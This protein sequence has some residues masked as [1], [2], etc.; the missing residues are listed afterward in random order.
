MKEFDA[1]K[2]KQN[3][4]NIYI[5]A[6][7]AKSLHIMTH[8]YMEKI[9]NNKD[10]FQ[11]T[12]DS[13]RTKRITEY[14]DRLNSMFPTAIVL[15]AKQEIK[16]KD[17]KINV[18]DGDDF[19]IIDGQHRIN[20]IFNSDNN[21]ELP[22]VITENL[23]DGMQSELFITINSEQKKVNSNVSFN[24]RGNDSVDTPEKF[25]V[26]VLKM[27][28]SDKDSALYNRIWMDDR[29]KNS[30]DNMISLAT[31]GTPLCNYIYNPDYYYNFKDLLILCK[32]DKLS[33]GIINAGITKEFEQ[34]ILWKLYINSKES[35]LFRIFDNY[36]SAIKEV[37]SEEWN[38]KNSIILKTIGF[39]ALI[40]L[41]KNVFIYCQKNNGNFT[42]E[43]IKDLLISSKIGKENFYTPKK[44]NEEI[45]IDG[46]EITLIG[47]AQNGKAGSVELYLMLKK[48]M[49]YEFEDNYSDFDYYID[50]EEYL[51]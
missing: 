5:C 10:L 43:F 13:T 21:Y 12:I 14:A 50:D 1:I 36:F 11:R 6:I 41:F 39:N 51:L 35:L 34:K 9:K 4:Y 40:M 42:K 27:L 46:K 16:F 20:G 44:L 26:N 45:K 19:F 32:N 3:S 49:G 8:E 17:N 33:E 18:D 24:M 48:S 28:N 15:N 37:Y 31:F 23:D 29:K 30:G 25:V 47:K 38:D 22:V 2:L 7:D